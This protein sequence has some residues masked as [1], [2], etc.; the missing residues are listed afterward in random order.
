VTRNPAR[1]LRNCEGKHVDLDRFVA[2]LRLLTRHR[3]VLPLDELVRGVLEGADL[4]GVVAITF[5]DG[6]ENNVTAAAPALAELG[7]PATFF[8]AT[9]YVDAARWLWVDRL[10]FALDAAE[11]RTVRVEG[12]GE[13]PLDD[14]A[15]ALGA[16]KRFAKQQPPSAVSRLVA[17]IEDQCGTPAGPPSGD[18]RFMSWPQARQLKAGGFEVGAHTVNH[19][20]LSR[21]S[22][23]EGEREMV[24]SRDAIRRELGACSDVFCYPNGK[25]ADLTPEIVACAARHFDAALATERGPARA[26]ERYALRRIGIGQ[27][28]TPDALAEVLLRER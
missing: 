3:R 27:A 17:E 25:V 4:R 10:E 8:L 24:E 2:Q 7:L 14:R 26:S 22:L 16:I 9:G 15:Q 1:G 21:V 28:T 13:V 18:Y 19:P 20:I 23:P 12:L 6:Y 11:R 5:D